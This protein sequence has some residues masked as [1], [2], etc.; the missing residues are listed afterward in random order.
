MAVWYFAYGSNLDFVQFRARC[1]SA[2]YVC[3][4]VLRDHILAFTRPS[5]MRNCGVADVVPQEGHDVWGVVYLLEDRDLSAL[6]AVEGFQSD[7]DPDR[8]AYNRKDHV[9]VAA[10]NDTKQALRVSLYIAVKRPNPPRPSEA[11]MGHI[12]D[13]AK[14]WKLPITYIE[15]LQRTPTL[16]EER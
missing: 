7:R 10:E 16:E 15:E 9:R 11:Y 1:P 6:D 3:R 13:G 8:N 5:T 12:I 2:Q 14:F 4:A